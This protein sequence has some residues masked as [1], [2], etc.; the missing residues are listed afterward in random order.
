MPVAAIYT[1]VRDFAQIGNV[2]LAF[3]SHDGSSFVLAGPADEAS[4]A[5]GSDVADRLRAQ[6]QAL[7]WPDYYR[8][9]LGCY[10][11]QQENVGGGLHRVRP[12]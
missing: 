3:V 1:L 11:E 8:T 10:R 7:L 2:P 4:Y 9:V 12:D 6:L 5:H